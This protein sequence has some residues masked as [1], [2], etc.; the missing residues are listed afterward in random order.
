M[1]F[2]EASSNCEPWNFVRKRGFV[3]LRFKINIKIPFMIHLKSKVYRKLRDSNHSLYRAQEVT[4]I[5][6]QFKETKL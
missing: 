5:F 4:P 1:I 2:L 3:Q 6:T